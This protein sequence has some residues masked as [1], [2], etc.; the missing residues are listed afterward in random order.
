MK[1]INVELVSGEL[2]T[3][4]VGME[5][6]ILDEDIAVVYGDKG[7]TYDVKD[8]LIQFIDP[9]GDMGSQNLSDVPENGWLTDMDGELCPIYAIVA[10]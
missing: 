1:S 9:D 5:P 7:N 8:V 10:F 4:S 2:V 6:P 3:L